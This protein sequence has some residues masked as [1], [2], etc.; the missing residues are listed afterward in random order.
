ASRVQR[1]GAAR[2]RGPPTHSPRG[3]T[4]RGSNAAPGLTGRSDGRESYL[5]R[6]TVMAVNVGDTAPDFELP[7]HHGKGKKVRLS[8]FRGKRNVL[9]AFYPLAWT[10]V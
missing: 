3:R 6:D 1:A 2:E 9:I 7:S 4:R 5:R 10:P 8:D